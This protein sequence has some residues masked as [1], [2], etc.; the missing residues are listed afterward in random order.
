[1]EK[2][3]TMRVESKDTKNIDVLG[4]LFLAI[5]VVVIILPIFFVKESNKSS[6][7]IG[8]LISSVD[9][10]EMNLKERMLVMERNGFSDSTYYKQIGEAKAELKLAR[11][12]LIE[13]NVQ[14]KDKQWAN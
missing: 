2:I 13:I 5:F 4:I 6:H 3:A 1:M 8:E 9:E 14:F 7:L 11:D 12:K 10:I